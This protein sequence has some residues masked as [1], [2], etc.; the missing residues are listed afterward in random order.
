MRH[1]FHFYLFFLLLL[2]TFPAAVTVNR[3]K[4][5]LPFWPI[6]KGIMNE[7]AYGDG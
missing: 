2:S 4:L 6:A 3:K 5:S 7:A 1:A